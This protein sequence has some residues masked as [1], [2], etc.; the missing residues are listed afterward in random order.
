[1]TSLSSISGDLGILVIDGDE[2]VRAWLTPTLGNLQ[3]RVV[4]ARDTVEGLER[5]H[6]ACP[7]LVI[8]NIDLPDASKFAAIQQLLELAP[9]LPIIVL[10]ERSNSDDLLKALRLGVSDYLQLPLAS[11]AMLELSITNSLR[12]AR[13][14]GE[15][16]RIRKKLEQINAEL[17]QRVQIFQ[18]DQQAGRHVQIN[19]MPIPPKDIGPFHFN[20]KVV[21]SLYLSGDTVDYKPASRHETLF[22]IADVSGHGS[23]SA[24]ITVL[25]RFRI[26]QMRLD[27]L[28]GRFEG[29]FTPAAILSVLNRDLIK[30]GLDKHVTVFMGI[31]N[32]NTNILQYSVAGH[33]PL[34]ILFQHG[35]AGTIPVERSSFPIGLFDGAP[36][37]DEQLTIAD[38]FALVLFSDG[39]LEVIKQGDYAAKEAHLR[40]VVQDS[41]GKFE[42]IK[43]ALSPPKN[44]QVP[45][46]IAIM[47]VTR[48]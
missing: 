34:P 15:N 42:E 41:K 6:S 8:I 28:R 26:E 14:I 25:L 13:L 35:V 21:P 20:H 31:L 5:F 40:Q 11:A 12:K 48:Q 2:A 4:L 19:M 27:H 29:E 1:M 17:E 45:D 43:A 32:D 3:L 38:D 44:M 16:H 22:Y 47:S 9:D 46:D 39:I 30:S 36:Y 33:H 10:A 23:S 24:F 18:Q 37:F 7:D